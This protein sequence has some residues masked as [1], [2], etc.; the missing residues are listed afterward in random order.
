MGDAMQFNFDVLN[1]YRKITR[2]MM[3]AQLDNGLVPDI[4]PEF[5][6]FE[7]GFRDS[8][9]WGSSSVIVPWLIYKNYG[10]ER[11]LLEAYPMMKR[12][13]KYLQSKS[14]NNLLHHGLGDWFDY[15][16]KQP[17]E[18]QLTPRALTAT[19]IYYYDLTLL[20]RIA[21]ILGKSN[22]AKDYEALAGQVKASFNEEFFDKKTKVYSTGSQTAAAMPL[23]VGL[24]D[25]SVKMDVVNNLVSSIRK[26]NNALTAGDIGFHFL[27]RSLS[28][29]NQSQI[30]FDMNARND[31]P[32]YGFQLAKGATALTES[33][34]ALENVS[35]NHLMLGHIMEWFYNGILG[36]NQDVQSLAY[37]KL[38]IRPQVVGDI[39][40]AKGDFL[41]PYG[42]VKCSW[43]DSARAF[44]LDVEVPVNVT[45]QIELPFGTSESIQLDGKPIKSH[46]NINVWLKG[47]TAVLFV[48]SGR[49][50]FSVNK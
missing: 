20:K 12:Y 19:A 15:G 43:R 6:V 45:A 17:G 30:I 11:I 22:E 28:E 37:K 16:P 38:I 42:V 9:E 7:S 2:D 41:S 21:E 13:V 26:S 5:V 46:K 29:N 50:A 8:P 33:W 10:D 40:W 27:I 24:V 48:G 31:V 1:L 14:K 39:Q 35:N 49:Y 3:D 36:I 32:G 4:A 44:F 18:A 47:D 23:C 34:P 25:E